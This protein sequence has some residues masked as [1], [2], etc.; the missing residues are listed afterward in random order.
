MRSD[1][2]DRGIPK[3]NSSLGF[4]RRKGIILIDPAVRRCLV[5]VA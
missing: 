3:P 1:W 5:F 4:L 2:L